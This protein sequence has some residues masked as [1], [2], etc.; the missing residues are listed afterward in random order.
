V[1]RG[2]Y[3]E[4]YGGPHYRVNALRARLFAV[5]ST[6]VVKK[7]GGYKTTGTQ[8]PKGTP[9]DLCKN[10]INAVCAVNAAGIRGK[11]KH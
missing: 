8:T 11:L 2:G 6:T 1:L 4:R 3:T 7:S 5:L 9:P 10:I